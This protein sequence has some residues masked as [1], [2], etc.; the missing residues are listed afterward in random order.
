MTLPIRFILTSRLLPLEVRPEWRTG[1]HPRLDSNRLR[2]PP[3]GGFHNC[4][5]GILRHFP[6]TVC[7]KAP[8]KVAACTSL[9]SV[10]FPQSWCMRPTHAPTMHHIFK[11]YPQLLFSWRSGRPDPL[12]AQFAGTWYASTQPMTS[13]CCGHRAFE[14]PLANPSSVAR[15]HEECRQWIGSLVRRRRHQRQAHSRAI[16]GGTAARTGTRQT[17]EMRRRW[18]APAELS[19]SL[20]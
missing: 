18:I 4:S 8:N 5:A 7:G 11:S 1:P 3:A 17:P 20:T 2:T 12:W 13:R 10:R 14:F 15:R 9:E 6:Q 16:P 19:D